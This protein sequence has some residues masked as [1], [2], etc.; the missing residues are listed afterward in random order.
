VLLSVP[1]GAR[2][3]EGVDSASAARVVESTIAQWR[4]ACGLDIRF[5]GATM[6]RVDIDAIDD[7]NMGRDGS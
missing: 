4:A 1:R 5:G 3:N 7:D 2:A 6:A